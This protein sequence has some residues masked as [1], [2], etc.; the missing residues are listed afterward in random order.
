MAIIITRIV[1]HNVPAKGSE[2]TTEEVDQNLINLKE[3]IDELESEVFV[4]RQFYS[5]DT[6]G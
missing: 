4:L 6:N 1:D 5:S 2:L 3:A